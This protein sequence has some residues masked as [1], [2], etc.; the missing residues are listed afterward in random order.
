MV[1]NSLGPSR[2]SASSIIIEKSFSSLQHLASSSSSF[3]KLNWLVRQNHLN[4]AADR[5][6]LLRCFTYT[7][8]WMLKTTWTTEKSFF[9]TNPVQRSMH[10]CLLNFLS[11]SSCWVAS[12]RDWEGWLADDWPPLSFFR[13]PFRLVERL[14]LDEENLLKR[15]NLYK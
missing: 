8:D 10:F 9:I 13:N 2:F 12:I 14:C 15:F 5:L 11:V 7:I 1:V 3:Q 6:S 4:S